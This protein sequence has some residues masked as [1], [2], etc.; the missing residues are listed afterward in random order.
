MLQPCRAPPQGRP[1]TACSS[2]SRADAGLPS[3]HTRL[4]STTLNAQ[5]SAHFTDLAILVSEAERADHNA[6]T[7][8]WQLRNREGLAIVIASLQI[9]RVAKKST[10]AEKAFR[11]STVYGLLCDGASRA[12]IVRFAAE[13]WDIKERMAENYI[14]DARVQIE[15]DCQLSRQQFLAETLAGLR[16]VRQSAGRRGQHQVVVNAIRL[17]AELVGLTG[18][19]A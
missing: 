2:S 4:P 17:Q 5:P 12:D 15:H 8:Y 19:T 6:N 9:V 16:Q 3:T 11:V 18:K 1:A 10:N 7:F 14:A 13:N